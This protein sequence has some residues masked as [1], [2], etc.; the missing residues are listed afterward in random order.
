MIAVLVSP[1]IS[2]NLIYSHLVISSI[3]C[4]LY[5]VLYSAYSMGNDGGR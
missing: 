4:T 5:A 3:L 1:A 2:G